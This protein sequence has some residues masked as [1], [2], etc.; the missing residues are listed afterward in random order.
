MSAND[1][2][3]AGSFAVIWRCIHETE[4]TLRR[5]SGWHPCRKPS[6]RTNR[7]DHARAAHH[8]AGIRL[9]GEDQ[10]SQKKSIRKSLSVQRFQRRWSSCRYRRLGVRPCAL[11]IMYIPVTVST[12]SS[13]PAAKW[14]ISSNFPQTHMLSLVPKTDPVFD[15]RHYRE[16]PSESTSCIRVKCGRIG[17]GER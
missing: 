8:D 13:H 14:S 3:R 4:C 5:D 16:G 15:S 7:G 2:K 6:A 9:Q 12:W 10:A 17:L 1:P 11:T